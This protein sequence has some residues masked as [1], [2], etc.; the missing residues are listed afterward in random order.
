MKKILLFISASFIVL[1][2]S[3]QNCET[4]LPASVLVRT[5]D[6]DHQGS[7]DALWLC[8]GLTFEI[9]GQ[10]NTVY[11]EKDGDLTITGNDQ[12][13]VYVKFPGSITINGNGMGTYILDSGVVVSG[14]A[15]GSA[16][17][18]TCG[19]PNHVKY[20]YDNVPATPGCIDTSSSTVGI[21]RAAVIENVKLY[22]NPASS[23]LNIEIGEESINSDYKIYS[24]SGKVILTGRL[25]D[26]NNIIDVS[27]LDKGLYFI[28]IENSTGKISKRI[29]IE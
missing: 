27:N 10:S 1:G 20:N 24:V 29:S 9:K 12:N 6:G 21:S 15:M 8:E 2:V 3:A 16:N 23:N 17:I 22:P 25:Y 14:S 7:G 19:S 28:E 18:T 11:M 13:T 4:T 26:F 5:M